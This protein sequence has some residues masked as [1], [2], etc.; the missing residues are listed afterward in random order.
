MLTLPVFKCI[1]HTFCVVYIYSRNENVTKYTYFVTWIYVFKNLLVHYN[2]LLH[3]RR[4]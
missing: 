3:H 2:C 4:F 1:V